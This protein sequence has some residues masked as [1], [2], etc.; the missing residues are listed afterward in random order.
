MT[1]KENQI[2]LHPAADVFLNQLLI[3]VGEENNKLKGDG[4][5]LQTACDFLGRIEFRLGSGSQRVISATLGQSFIL[6]NAIGLPCV[7]V[8]IDS[9]PRRLS[10]FGTGK[11]TMSGQIVGSFPGVI[12]TITTADEDPDILHVRF[13]I[14]VHIVVEGELRGLSQEDFLSFDDGSFDDDLIISFMRTGRGLQNPNDILFVPMMI[15]MLVTRDVRETIRVLGPLPR[16]ESEDSSEPLPVDPNDFIEYSPQSPSDESRLTI[17]AS[18]SG[19]TDCQMT[20]LDE[21]RDLK[22]MSYQLSKVE[23]QIRTVEIS[24]TVE[25]TNFSLKDGGP[26]NDVDGSPVWRYS[27]RMRGVPESIIPANNLHFLEI[28]VSG[29]RSDLKIMEIH[30]TLDED[31]TKT[32][33]FSGTFENG[34]KLFGVFDTTSVPEM[35]IDAFEELARGY[36]YS[37]GLFPPAFTLVLTHIYFPLHSVENTLN[38]LRAEA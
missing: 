36:L 10:D 8:P 11:V 7:C 29:I 4:G 32:T 22:T 37:E 35:D 19:Y 30:V 21:N 33:H 6:D 15:F 27:L 24:N 38:V 2:A 3:E 9:T 5:R 16:F 23:E 26:G 12:D 1:A 34:A 28:V 20:L 17:I 25:D 31:G 13:I 18:L 14:S